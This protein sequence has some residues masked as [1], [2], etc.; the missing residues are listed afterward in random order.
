MF[1]TIWSD[2]NVFQ[3]LDI[4]DFLQLK[5]CSSCA[6]SLK[7]SMTNNIY[8]SCSKEIKHLLKTIRASYIVQLRIADQLHNFRNLFHTKSSF[9]KQKPGETVT[10]K[11]SFCTFPTTGIGKLKSWKKN[12]FLDHDL[13]TPSKTC[14]KKYGH[15]GFAAVKTVEWGIFEPV[16]KYQSNI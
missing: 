4:S 5:K 3:D 16:A 1:W 11:S 14:T 7:T 2:P 6:P 12:W 9:K 10:F 15:I 13:T 8:N